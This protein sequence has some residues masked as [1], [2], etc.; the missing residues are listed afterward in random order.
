MRQSDSTYEDLDPEDPV[1]DLA[2]L[3]RDEYLGK[4]EGSYNPMALDSI[5]AD[6]LKSKQ[7]Q[8]AVA[9][10]VTQLVQSPEFKRACQVL[11]KELWNDLVQDPETLSQVIHLLH[12]AIQ[13]EQIKE[14][15]VKLVMEIVNDKE[16]LEELKE[17]VQKLGR[18]KEVCALMLSLS[19]CLIECTLQQLFSTH[20]FRIRRFKQQHNHC[21]WSV[22]IMH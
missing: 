5:L 21:S 15:A 12:N 17:L 16:V 1:A 9:G 13:D 18:D 22:L 6:L 2:K 14:A 10:L 8:E 3:I 4:P 19:A 20:T 7:V 11:L